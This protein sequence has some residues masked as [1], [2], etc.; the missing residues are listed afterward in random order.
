[1]HKQG[2]TIWSRVIQGPN[3][4][5]RQGVAHS[6]GSKQALK[7]TI[8]LVILHVFCNLLLQFEFIFIFY[9]LEGNK[10]ILK[11]ERTKFDKKKKKKKLTRLS[12]P[13]TFPHLRKPPNLRALSLSVA[14]VYR[15][16]QL[17]LL[18]VRRPVLPA[19]LLPLARVVAAS[20]SPRI[21]FSISKF[22]LLPTPEHR[23]RT[24]QLPRCSH[25]RHSALC[26]CRRRSL[27]LS[28]W[29]II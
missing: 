10:I 13:Y 24:T 11:A 28:F 29:G 12:L 27:I 4:W 6:T 23:G 9:S 26:H 19:F 17:R 3:K 22:C 1:M 14:H 8:F 25:D 15:R 20:K 7:F 18:R 5:A 16:S 2:V 21:S